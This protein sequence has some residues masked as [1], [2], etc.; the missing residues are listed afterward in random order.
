MATVNLAALI[1]LW[2][3]AALGS[4]STTLSSAP[5]RAL[6]AARST[7]RTIHVDNHSPRVQTTPRAYPDDGSH[8]MNSHDEFIIFDQA[9][10]LFYK[11]GI[12]QPNCTGSDM[13]KGDRESPDSSQPQ[14]SRA[15]TS[16]CLQPQFSHPPR[17][18]TVT[19]L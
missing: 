2:L 7:I 6:A 1:T 16:C 9:T 13:C 5:A 11:W 17:A 18:H 14:T 10:A 4:H 3:L 19:A 15:A 12:T 8:I